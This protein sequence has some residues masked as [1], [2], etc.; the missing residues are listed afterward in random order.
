M[1]G[2]QVIYTMLDQNVKDLTYSLDVPSFQASGAENQ[3]DG[4]GRL[5]WCHDQGCS[6]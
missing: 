2:I 1:G 4:L 6:A 5:K 3:L